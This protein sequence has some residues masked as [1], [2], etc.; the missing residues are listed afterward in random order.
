MQPTV[1][2]LNPSQLSAAQDTEP[3]ILVVAKAGSGKTR[4]LVERAKMLVADGFDQR[5][6]A[7]ITYTN[8]GA[9]EFTRRLSPL[10]PGFTGTLHAF[11]LRLIAEHNPNIVL[12]TLLDEELR[13]PF[14]EQVA[15][16]IC[17]RTTFSK[18]KPYL[19]PWKVTLHY[20]T[21]AQ[22]E[23]LVAQQYYRSLRQNH[24]LDFD[25]V[26]HEGWKVLVKMVDAGTFPFS[27]VLWDEVQ[28]CAE[29]DW[30]IMATI[31]A[32]VF[33]VGDPDQSV[34]GFRGADSGGM[35]RLW[36]SPGWACY[37]LKTNYR[38]ADLI[39]AAASRLIAKNHDRVDVSMVADRKGGV[40]HAVGLPSPIAELAWVADSIARESVDTEATFAVLARTNAVVRQFADHFRSMGIPVRESKAP[41]RPVDWKRTKLLLSVLAD[42][43]NDFVLGRYLTM[44]LGPEV[45]KLRIDGAKKATVS[46]NRLL[47]DSYTMGRS[48]LEQ[49]LQKH[50]VSAESRLLVQEAAEELEQLEQQWSIADLS[51]VLNAKEQPLESGPG[52]VVST[53][54]SAKGTEFSHVYVVGCEDQ[55][56]PGVRADTNV[57]EERRL[58]YVAMT[59]AMDKLT[60]TW[61]NERP[62]SRGPNLPPGPMQ[63]RNKS[64]FIA[65]AGL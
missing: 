29:P 13:E 30:K 2:P 52:V 43:S 62:Q 53:I 3:R 32:D 16:D 56:F 44:M 33:A 1:T 26:L 25:M 46:L 14:V 61:C 40:V 51:M 6:L 59:R 20:G 31:P 4:T 17:V 7:V 55:S 35:Y 38:C 64:R 22:R 41:E 58:M 39:C 19:D 60:I 5:K 11:M 10:K 57:D 34:F 65:E 23:V 63:S 12:P 36:K 28:D 27:H 48:T 15:A 18:V 42:P 50:G 45:A 8:V 54:H 21:S 49:M 9:R 24:M 37:A 47:D